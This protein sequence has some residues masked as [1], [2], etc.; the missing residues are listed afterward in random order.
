MKKFVAAFLAILLLLTCVSTLAEGVD[1]ESLSDEEIIALLQRVEQEIVD[2]KIEATATLEKGVYI[3]GKDIPVGSYTFTC[4]AT[5]DDWGN[6][7][8]TSDEGQGSQLLWEV[9]GAPEGD[10]KPE[11]FK[12]TINENDELDSGVPFSLT[13]YTGIKFE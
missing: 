1:L 4:L 2:R 13:I 7:T 10:E 5:G 3:G 11:S 8:V 9:V 6:V 12:V